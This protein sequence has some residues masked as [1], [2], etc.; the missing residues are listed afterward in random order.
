[1]GTRV[2]Q[3]RYSKPAYAFATAGVAVALDSQ[4]LSSEAVA[5]ELDGMLTNEGARRAA[6]DLA[7]HFAAMPHPN[8]V[9]AAIT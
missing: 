9:L 1:V 7:D 3:G 6:A 2:A 5:E 4:N 8:H